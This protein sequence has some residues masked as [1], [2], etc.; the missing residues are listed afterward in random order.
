MKYRA[1]DFDTNRVFCYDDSAFSTHE[2]RPGDDA[3][4]TNLSGG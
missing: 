1:I 4:T 3:K 2:Y